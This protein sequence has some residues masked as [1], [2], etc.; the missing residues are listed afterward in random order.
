MKPYII[1]NFI[2]NIKREANWINL[3][4]GENLEGWEAVGGAAEF[5]VKDGEIIGYAKANTPNTF[6]YFPTGLR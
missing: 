5:K 1:V 4:N 3:F 2:I 6:L